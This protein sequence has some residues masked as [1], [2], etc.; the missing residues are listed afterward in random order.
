MHPIRTVRQIIAGRAL[1]DDERAY[2]IIDR[3]FIA[4]LVLEI[5][6]WPFIPLGPLAVSLG[7]TFTRIR[8]SRLRTVTLWAVASVLT[9]IVIVPLGVSWLHAAIG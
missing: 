9:L 3:L 2:P 6:V 7:A 1:T 4:F 8:S 5:V